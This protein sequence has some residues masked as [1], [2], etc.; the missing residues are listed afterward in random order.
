VSEGRT[1]VIGKP[2]SRYARNRRS[3]QAILLRE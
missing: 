1:I 3:S 2:S